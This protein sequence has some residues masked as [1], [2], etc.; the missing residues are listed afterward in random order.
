MLARGGSK[1]IKLKN[2][3]KIGNHSLLMRSLNSIRESKVFESVW[4][5]TDHEVIEKEAIEGMF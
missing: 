5:S 3:V 4:V 1:G 2:L